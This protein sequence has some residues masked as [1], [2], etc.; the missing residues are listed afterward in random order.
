VVG[1]PRRLKN[2]FE[3]NGPSQRK[4]MVSGKNEDQHQKNQQP[5][6][7]PPAGVGVPASPIDGYQGPPEWCKHSSSVVAHYRKPTWNV[8]HKF[9]GSPGKEKKLEPRRWL[10]RGE[11]ASRPGSWVGR[12]RGALQGEKR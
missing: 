10:I 4:E 2:R 11:K 1:Q 7:I 8:N 3:K 12:F 5:V 9:G 6:A